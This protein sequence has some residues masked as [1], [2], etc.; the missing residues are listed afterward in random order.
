MENSMNEQY[1]LLNSKLKKLFLIL[2]LFPLNGCVEN[3][4]YLQW[5]DE[6]MF[7]YRP[8]V[9][10]SAATRNIK[11]KNNAGQVVTADTP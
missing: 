3:G 5:Y 8:S 2:L 9:I 10:E 7:L 11:N 4:M 1:R 6:E